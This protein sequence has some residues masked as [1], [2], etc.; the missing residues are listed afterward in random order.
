MGVAVPPVCSCVG[1]NPQIIQDGENGFLARTEREWFEKISRLIED[2]SLRRQMGQRAREDVER[3][4]SV[5]H[6]APHYLDILQKVS[7]QR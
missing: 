1:V 2:E 6:F 7:S 4:Y 3:F 5:R